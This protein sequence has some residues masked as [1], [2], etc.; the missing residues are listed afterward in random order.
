MCYSAAKVFN[1]SCYL[2]PNCRK[3]A[4]NCRIIMIIATALAIASC[5]REPDPVLT[6]SGD[7]SFASSV[8]AQVF[9]I[10][11]NRDWTI[12]ASEP[13]V[14][15]SPK[16]GTVTSR[17]EEQIF[18]VRVS[19]M[20]NDGYDSRDATLTVEHAEG[21]LSKSVTLKQDQKNAILLDRNVYIAD[22]KAQE[23]VVPIETNVSVSAQ[24]PSGAS[25][26]TSAQTRALRSASVVLSLDSNSGTEVRSAEVALK[27]DGVEMA[28]TVKQMPGHAAID[29][30]IPGVYPKDGDPVVY[31]KGKD[32]LSIGKNSSGRFFRLLVQDTPSVVS[33][34]GI[35]DS[36]NLGDS[37]NV[38]VELSAVRGSRAENSV[39]VIAILSEA[40]LL[41]LLREDREAA[42]LIKMQEP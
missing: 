20:A 22:G 7:P 2:C 15:V 17:K 1:K 35:P 29:T 14:A 19:C 31:R 8:S 38:S 40:N 24:I 5:Q 26:I 16:S 30:G 37:F 33:I 10:T 41:C 9:T 21:G 6:V 18:T 34:Y 32:Q 25:W 23:I 3:Q 27:G 13:W 11:T 12:S 42:Y 4:M 39:P 36:V 28:V